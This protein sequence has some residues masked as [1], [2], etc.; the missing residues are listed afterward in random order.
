[1]S[2]QEIEK[3]HREMYQGAPEGGRSNR[4]PEVGLGGDEDAQPPNPLPYEERSV[5]GG[6]AAEEAANKAF[7][8]SNAGEPGPGLSSSGDVSA[9]DTSAESPLG[10]GVSTTKRGE[11]VA[12]DESESGRE[13]LGTKG[14]SDRPV[15]TASPEDSTGVDPQGTIDDD[16]PNM[17]SGDQG[18]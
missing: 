17:V 18:G 4:G 15:G 14:K 8:A 13:D 6:G 2:E 3:Q 1:M 7:D 9:T 12:K 11:D 5:G 16:M 10:V